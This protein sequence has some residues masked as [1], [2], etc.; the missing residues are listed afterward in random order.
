MK[1]GEITVNFYCVCYFNTEYNDAKVIDV[2][3]PN[4]RNNIDQRIITIA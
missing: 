4:N 1:S 3:K 2:L